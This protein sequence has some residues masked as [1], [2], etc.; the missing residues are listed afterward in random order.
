MFVSIEVSAYVETREV[1]PGIVEGVV[2]ELNEL[3]CCCVTVSDFLFLPSMYS[4]LHMLL[5]C[6]I[7]DSG[8][9][10]LRTSDVSEVYNKKTECMLA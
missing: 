7:D 8:Q 1:A 6:L 9:R 3:L 2:V 4:S 5:R 10:I